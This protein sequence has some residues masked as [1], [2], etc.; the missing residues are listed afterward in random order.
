[1][2]SPE[3]LFKEQQAAIE[4]QFNKIYNPK[5]LKQLARKNIKINDK[6]L[7]KELARRMINPNYFIDENLKI[8]FKINLES[9]DVNHAKSLLNVIPSF[10][11]I[12]IEIRKF[13]KS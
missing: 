6:D 4:K 8:G 3:W 9:H 12:G 10:P 13:L 5:T 2:I 7:D 11:D 1:M